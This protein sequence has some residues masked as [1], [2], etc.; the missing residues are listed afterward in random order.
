MPERKLSL[1]PEAGD[2]SFRGLAAGTAQTA[3]FRNAN[4]AEPTA[5]RTFST[6][7]IP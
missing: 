3:P 6:V 1:I 5:F 4:M 2:D 7:I